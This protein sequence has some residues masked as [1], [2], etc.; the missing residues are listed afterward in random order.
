MPAQATIH[1]LPAERRPPLDVFRAWPDRSYL[2]ALISA[3]PSSP[4]SRWSI[5]AKPEHIVDFGPAEP[6]PIA[7]LAELVES[8][9]VD[10]PSVH[11]HT[12]FV[13]GW[14]VAL[15]YELGRRIEP[16]SGVHPSR[17]DPAWPSLVTLWRCPAALVHDAVEDRWFGVRSDPNS[18]EAAV[19][20]P[21][22]HAPSYTLGP[23]QG[24][25]RQAE[26][27]AAVARTVEYI[28]AG[29]AFQ[30]NL[31]HRLSASFDGSTRALFLDLCR[32]TG[33]WYGAYLEHHAQGRRRA[34]VSLS[35]ELMLAY[36]ATT[37][38]LTTR[39]IKGT[40]PVSEA[41]GQL[42][43]SLKDQAELNMI[44]DLM[45]NDLGRVAAIGSVRVDQARVI[46]SHGGASGVH[47]GVATI[48][49]RLAAGR[50]LADLLRATFP[51]GSITGA[52]KVRAMQ[53]IEELEPQARGLYT[54]A[55][56]FISDC[57]NLTLNIPIRTAVIDG[58]GFDE[59]A[60]KPLIRGATLHY[61]V[62]AG[63]V[64]DSVPRAEWLETLDKAGAL[65]KPARSAT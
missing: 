38:L 6:D 44:V 8:T 24:L 27:E 61:G 56:G 35:P 12:P 5:L 25:T 33:P 45:R 20:Q 28:R 49:A 55:V 41:P 30:V 37:R 26:F 15:S 9:R 47:Q 21:R 34:A 39:P 51:G 52:P 62:G 10:R 40:R 58:D 64:A 4:W 59:D 16:R 50:S 22:E 46:E 11:T 1:P 17:V 14:L 57:G 63:I 2:A 42:D 19:P 53:I 29:D 18:P 65:L 7:R 48:R 43:A 54:G 32:Q 36:D 31:A 3:D 23:V 13:G 60:P